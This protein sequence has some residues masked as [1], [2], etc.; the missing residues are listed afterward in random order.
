MAVLTS[1]CSCEEW[2]IVLVLT[3][4]VCSPLTMA[5]TKIE[6]NVKLME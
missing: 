3:V 6:K 2:W 4:F 5:E 1:D